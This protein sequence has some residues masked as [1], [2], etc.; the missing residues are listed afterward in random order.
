MRKLFSLVKVSWSLIFASAGML[1]IF[2]AAD[3]VD[4]YRKGMENT[5]F[6]IVAHYWIII[7]YTSL[8]FTRCLLFSLSYKFSLSEKSSLNSNHLLKKWAFYI[9]LLVIWIFLDNAFFIGDFVKL[10]VLIAILEYNRVISIER[11]GRIFTYF[12]LFSSLLSGVISSATFYFLALFQ[13]Q[14]I[15][16]N[17]VWLYCAIGVP[18]SMSVTMYDFVRRDHQEFS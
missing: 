9:F 14:L 1:L 17:F 4:Q 15:L 8:V 5:F 18:F 2:C 11:G 7:C 16:S 3:L 10:L 12:C 6:M 13:G